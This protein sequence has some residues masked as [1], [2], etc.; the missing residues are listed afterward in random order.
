[1]RSCKKSSENKTEPRAR[2]SAMALFFV[3]RINE[4]RCNASMFYSN[5]LNTQVKIMNFITCK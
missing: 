1:M 5:A 2:K 4:H 3:I